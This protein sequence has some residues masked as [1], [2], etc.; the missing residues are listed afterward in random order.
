MGEGDIFSLFTSVEGGGYPIQPTGRGY[1]HLRSGWGYPFQRQDPHPPVQVRSQD[2]GG[3]GT[4][5]SRS[6]PRM[7]GW[8]R[9]PPSRSDPR[10]GGGTPYQ[11]S[12][13]CTCYA[14]GSMPLAFT[15]EDFLVTNNIF[16][17]V[18]ITKYQICKL[19]FWFCIQSI[20]VLEN[21][22]LKMCILQRKICI[23]LHQ[24]EKKKSCYALQACSTSTELEIIHSGECDGIIGSGGKIVVLSEIWSVSAC[25]LYLSELWKGDIVRRWVT[26][27]CAEWKGM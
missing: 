18:Q 14:A 15:Q 4:A 16:S 13:A 19:I 22:F 21:V 27:C 11:N 1:P 24:N 2:R 26:D 3:R 25:E 17:S 23:H 9:V 6:D 20:S 5:L 8:G 12:I 10:M 7:M